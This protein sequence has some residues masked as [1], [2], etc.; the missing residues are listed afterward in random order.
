MRAVE[1]TKP[2]SAADGRLSQGFTEGLTAR[3]LRAGFVEAGG[4]PSVGLPR[5]L[6]VFELLEVPAPFDDGAAGG[7]DTDESERI[8]SRER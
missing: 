1:A 4:D 5:V 6:D 7:E 8:H 2:I 3:L